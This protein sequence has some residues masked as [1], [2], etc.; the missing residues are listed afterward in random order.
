[1]LNLQEHKVNSLNRTNFRGVATT[2]GC[3][4]SISLRDFVAWENTYV[5]AWNI[6]NLFIKNQNKA[7]WTVFGLPS[8]YS[9]T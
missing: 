4:F 7:N 1:M 9:G 3:L 5:V 2:P 6:S 8:A